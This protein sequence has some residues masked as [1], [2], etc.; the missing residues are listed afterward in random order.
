MQDNVRHTKNYTN[1]KILLKV[2]FAGFL[3]YL[4]Q[5]TNFMPKHNKIFILVK[6]Y[7]ICMISFFLDLVY[8]SV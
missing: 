3:F 8:G 4:L 7:E 2:F 6:M 5:Y 1:K